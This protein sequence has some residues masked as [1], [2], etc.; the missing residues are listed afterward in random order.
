MRFSR[1]GSESPA[2]AVINRFMYIQ[3]SAPPVTTLLSK[4]LIRDVRGAV[5]SLKKEEISAFVRQHNLP[6][7]SEL[8]AKAAD[9]LLLM[10]VSHLQKPHNKHTTPLKT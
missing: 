7:Q 3:T 8:N 1:D 10:K 4:R 2:A 5:T 6:H 9:P